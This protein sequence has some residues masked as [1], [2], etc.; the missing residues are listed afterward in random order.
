MAATNI[1][2]QT[3]VPPFEYTCDIDSEP[4]HRYTKGGY[5]PIHLGDQLKH[6]RYRVLHKLGW[7]GHSTV[8]AALDQEHGRYVAVKISTSDRKCEQIH[9]QLKVMRA[10]AGFSKNMEHPGAAAVV[11]LLDHFQTDGPNGTHECLV[12][13]LLGPSITDVLDA[14]FKDN[15]LPAELARKIARQALL[16]VDYL[17]QHG[18]G[19]GGMC[20]QIV[21]CVSKIN[22]IRPTYAE[23][24]LYSSRL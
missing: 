13:E 11:R 19:H 22:Q 6:G 12:L 1:R 18:I 15:R 17:H 21:E 5:H 23:H 24:R 7:G 10:I 14:R 2:L 8:W 4:L 20:Y 16:G 3:T 9:R